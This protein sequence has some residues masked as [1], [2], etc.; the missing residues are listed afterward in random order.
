MFGDFLGKNF[1]PKICNLIFYFYICVINQGKMTHERI[2]ELLANGA[3]RL[4]FRRHNVTSLPDNLTVPD[5][6]DLEGCGIEHLPKMLFV[7][8]DLDLRRTLIQTLPPC[9]DVGY[10]RIYVN[11]TPFCDEVGVS[12]CGFCNRTI[13][14]WQ[15]RRDGLVI[16]IGC[17]RYTKE[18][19]INR[20]FFEYRHHEITRDDYI[21]KVHLAFE[22]YEMH[23]RNL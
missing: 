15:H 19:A 8:G 23:K 14:C 1:L 12:N 22:K 4:D 2:L 7:G 11:N 16:Q 6:L 3:K 17:T 20:I 18:N 5:D 9:L 21:A 10:G 13:F